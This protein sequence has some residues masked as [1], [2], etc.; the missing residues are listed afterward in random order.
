MI[1]NPVKKPF[2]KELDA[3]G[4]QLRKE[5]VSKAG[6]DAQQILDEYYRITGNQ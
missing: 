1:I 2:R 6:K 4:V 5:W 3:I